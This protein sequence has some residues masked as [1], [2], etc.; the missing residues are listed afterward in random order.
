[1]FEKDFTI[2][3]N[4]VNVAE[5]YSDVIL[6]EGDY[7][8]V[9]YKVRDL[10]YLNHTLI[11]HPLPASIRMLYSPIRSIALK[12]G[13]SESSIILIEDSINKY[14]VTMGNRKP[15]YRNFKDYKLL[16]YEL[17]KESVSID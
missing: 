6:V 3:T 2:V 10:V 4:N 5:H 12:K 8:D 11:N 9:L 1:M 14:L 7:L 15:D 13:K 17:L 16:D